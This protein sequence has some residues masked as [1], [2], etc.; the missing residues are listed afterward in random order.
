MSKSKWYTFSRM[1]G[2]YEM[3]W[4]RLFNIYPDPRAGLGYKISYQSKGNQ[5]LISWFGSISKIDFKAN[6]KFKV[7][8]RRWWRFQSKAK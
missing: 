5:N 2:V 3:K 8:F 7:K 4:G 6:Q 1:E